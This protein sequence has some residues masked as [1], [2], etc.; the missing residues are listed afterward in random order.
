MTLIPTVADYPDFTKE[1]EF[2]TAPIIAG[3]FNP[4]S[5][6]LVIGTF[7]TGGFE[8]FV[9]RTSNQ[10]AGLGWVYNFAWYA[11]AALTNQIGQANL[12]TLSAIPISAQLP[13]RGPFCRATITTNAVAA[14]PTTVVIVPRTGSPSGAG[15]FLDGL[16]H[17]GYNQVIAG[18]AT[19]A[20]NAFGLTPGPAAM[21]VVTSAA[22]WRASVTGFDELSSQVGV[23]AGLNSAGGTHQTA[24]LV[25]PPYWTQIQITNNDAGNQ[26]F[27]FSVQAEL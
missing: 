18:G 27:H 10:F 26:T 7:Y 17:G 24:R 21:T 5:T 23:F 3:T 15:A 4:S 19:F 14:H 6:G 20:Q 22:S 13:N 9:V 8:S 12:R 25:L 1:P 11:D 16:V 2:T